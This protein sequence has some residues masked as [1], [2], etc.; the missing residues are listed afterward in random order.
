ML[1]AM[2]TGHDGS[3]TTVHANTRARC[4][5]RVEQMIG[6]GGIDCLEVGP[7][8]NRLCDQRHDPDRAADG[9]AGGRCTSVS[10]LTGMEGEVITIQEISASVRREISEGPGLGQVRGDRYSAEVHRAGHG[11]RRYSVCRPV[12]SRREARRMNEAW[13]KALILGCTFGAVLLAR[14]SGCG[15]DGQHSVHGQS[16]QPPG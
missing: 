2:N 10:E 12:P 11:P 9:R 8:A 6:M 14:R 13:I 16:D 4:P 1:Q 15:L 5:V 7:R 3:M